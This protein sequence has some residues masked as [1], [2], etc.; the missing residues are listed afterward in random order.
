MRPQD[1]MRR[2]ES[3]CVDAFCKVLTP[4]ELDSD[5]SEALATSFYE[6]IADQLQSSSQEPSEEQWQEVLLDLL[7]GQVKDSH[8]SASSILLHLQFQ[9]AFHVAQ[10]DGSGLAEEV[11]VGA[12]CVA[13]LVEDGEWHEAKVVA[14]KEGQL[15]EVEFDLGGK[16]QEVD[17]TQLC[18]LSEVMGDDGEQEDECPICER[19]RTSR[20]ETLL[21]QP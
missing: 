13:V 6:E 10:D 21:H 4:E 2:L 9:G 14:A 7:A 11:T 8:D 20:D 17:R 1:A 3:Q 18:L 15:F 19:V 16:R 12:R 5:T